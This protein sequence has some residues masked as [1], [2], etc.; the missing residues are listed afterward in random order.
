VFTPSDFLDTGNRDA[1]DKALSRLRTK[2]VIRRLDH[3]VYDYPK[4]S[5]RTGLR[6]PDPDQ[7]ATR[8][9]HK[10]NARV[11]RTGAY[12]ANAL[13]LSTQVPGSAVFLTD[14]PNRTV[15]AGAVTLKLKRTAPKNLVGAGTTSG[16]V[17]QAL[18][19]LGRTNMDD[20]VVRTL[21]RRLSPS[22]KKCLARDAAQFVGW[23]RPIIARVVEGSKA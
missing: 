8:L 18:R 21:R 1:V 11:H 7:V 16:D 10:N 20:Q 6:S 2:G 5:S 22:D 4:H 15:R 19:Y 14:G 17:F 23:M 9:A 3:G 12:T 13:G